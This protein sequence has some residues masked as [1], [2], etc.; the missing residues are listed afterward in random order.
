MQGVERR[1]AHAAHTS[2][3][4]AVGFPGFRCPLTPLCVWIPTA[5][6]HPRVHVARAWSLDHALRPRTAQRTVSSA[7]EAAGVVDCAVQYRAVG[8][9]GG[10]ASRRSR[11]CASGPSTNMKTL[12]YANVEVRSPPPASTHVFALPGLGA[13]TTGHG[14]VKSTA[15]TQRSDQGWSRP[16]TPSHH[17]DFR[18]KRPCLQTA[19]HDP[20]DIESGAGGLTRE[21]ETPLPSNSP[22]DPM[23]THPLRRSSCSGRPH[24]W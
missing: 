9:L 13:N 23:L 4:P 22:P 3:V 20:Y 5:T 24:R 1:A 14:Q 2:C 11:D 21:V 12:Q 10:G 19:H 7:E 17:I 6:Q 16:L 18:Q 15:S 8:S